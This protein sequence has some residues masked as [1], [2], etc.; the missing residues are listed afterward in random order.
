[1]RIFA[2]IKRKY[3]KYRGGDNLRLNGFSHLRSA[4]DR[5][6]DINLLQPGVGCYKVDGHWTNPNP[7]RDLG[8]TAFDDSI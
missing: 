4:I 3:K 8:I 1:M 7:N 2:N 6:Y 5:N